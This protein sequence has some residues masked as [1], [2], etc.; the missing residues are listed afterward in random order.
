MKY[1]SVITNFGCHYK[2]PYCIVKENNLHIPRTTLSGLNNLEEAL[3]ENNCD[4]VS[5]SGGGDPL[6]E[7]EKHIDWYRKFFGIAHKRNVFFKPFRRLITVHTV[8][9]FQ[10]QE[11]DVIMISLVRANDKGRIGF[12]GDLRRMNVAITRARMKLMILGDAPTLTR[13]VFYKE[14]YEYI[15]ENG[16][17]V[18]V[19]PLPPP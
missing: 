1:M 13:H 10:G 12:L 9:G 7:Y 6:H 8:D 3:K 15:R 19:H 16:Q 11:R 18:D 17:V 2:C 4:I 5:I 14:L